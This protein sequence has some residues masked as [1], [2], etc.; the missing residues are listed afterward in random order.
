MVYTTR[1]AYI[2]SEMGVGACGGEEKRLLYTSTAAAAEGN[3][4][5]T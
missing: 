2:G 4:I 1:M 3:P 5:R